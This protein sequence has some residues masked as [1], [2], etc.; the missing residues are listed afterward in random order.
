MA[1]F[2]VAGLIAA[3]GLGFCLWGIYQYLAASLGAAPAALL[4][5]VASLAVAGGLL[6]IGQRISR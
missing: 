5:G 3:A 6:W 4:T 2:A 1:L